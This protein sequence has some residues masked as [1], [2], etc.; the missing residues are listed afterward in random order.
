MSD[1]WLLSAGL[2]YDSSMVD[3][4]DRT[5]DLPGG[6]AWRFGLS[7]RCDW[8][9]QLA[10]GLAYEAFRK[11]EED[12]NQKLGDIRLTEPNINAGVKYLRLQ[13][14]STGIHRAA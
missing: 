7:A 9:Q 14:R 3:D 12:L 11:F 13:T 2:A 5:A 1:P 10:I 4:E 8:P 6:E